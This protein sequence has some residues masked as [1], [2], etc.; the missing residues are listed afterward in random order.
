MSEF[1]LQ[2]SFAVKVYDR[3]LSMGLPLFAGTGHRNSN[4]GA[5]LVLAR[6]SF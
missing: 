2:A 1:K 6:L 5:F 4:G 3:I